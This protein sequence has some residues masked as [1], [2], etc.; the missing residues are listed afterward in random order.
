MSVSA[1]RLTN[2]EIAHDCRVR[3]FALLAG[4]DGHRGA[5]NEGGRD[6]HS[7]EGESELL[8]VVF[9]EV[10]RTVEIRIGK[11]LAMF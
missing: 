9:L 5:A 2:G 11:K 1:L 4:A 8:H 10:P 3:D 6:N 7:R